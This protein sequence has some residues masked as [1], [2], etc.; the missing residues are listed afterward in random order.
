M[1]QQRIKSNRLQ[2]KS[3]EKRACSH[4][5]KAK[6]IVDMKIKQSTEKAQ[7]RISQ[8]TNKLMSYFKSK[9]ALELEEEIKTVQKEVKQ[10]Q[11]SK[12]L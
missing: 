12:Y 1:I 6:K 2:D 3:N 5:N 8:S 9:Q 11:Y 10:I 7:G 4:I